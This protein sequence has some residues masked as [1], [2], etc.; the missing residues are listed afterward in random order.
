[1]TFN[2][3]ACD[4]HAL[5]LSVK[6]GVKLILDNQVENDAVAVGGNMVV[7]N[8]IA[9]PRDYA[10]ALHELGHC[11]GDK[12]SDVLQEERAA[13]AWAQENAIYWDEEMTTAMVGGLATYAP[14][15]KVYP[16]APARQSVGSFLDGIGIKGVRR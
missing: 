5:E 14:F 1:M 15:R 7:T 16:V 11:R 13:W 4:A 9:T 12:F 6:L 2:A 3:N 8:E 10:V